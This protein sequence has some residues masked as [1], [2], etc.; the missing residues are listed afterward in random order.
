MAQLRISTKFR[1]AL[2]QL[3]SQTDDAIDELCNIIGSNPEILTSRQ[4]AFDKASTLTKINADDGFAFLEALIPLLYFKASHP[5]AS[6]LKDVS[7]TLTRSEDK[8]APKLD[9]SLVSRFE[10]NLGQILALS[11]VTLKAKALSVA[12]DS[13]RLFSEARILSDMR[14]VF[15]EDTSKAPLGVVL[16]HNLKIQFAEDGEEREFFVSLDAQDLRELQSCISRALEKE[17]SLSR[18]A[19]QSK[20][21]L[22]DTSK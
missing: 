11:E 12:T 9:S 2:V 18:F 21:K 16:L 20:L 8:E 5:T 6:V 3:A 13:Q 1:R 17:A 14:P 15:G 10:K 22:F 4:A 7:S 19:D